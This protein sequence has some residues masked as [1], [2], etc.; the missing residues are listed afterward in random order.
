VLQTTV[1]K[2]TIKP[3]S[4]CCLDWVIVGQVLVVNPAHAV[5]RPSTSCAA[6]N[7]PVL[8]EEQARRLLESLDTLNCRRPARSRLSPHVPGLCPATKT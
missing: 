7:T 3:L 4:A 2:P 1:A 5:R 8:T 6:R